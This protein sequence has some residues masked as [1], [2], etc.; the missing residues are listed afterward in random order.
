MWTIIKYDKKKLSFLKNDF[1]SKLGKDFIFYNPRLKI[2]KYNKNKLKKIEINLLGDYIFCFHPKFQKLDKVKDNLKYCRGLK[3]FL[4]GNHESQSEIKN[5][6]HKC[7]SLEDNDGFV[8]KTFFELSKG[9]EYKFS[10]GPFTSQIFKIINFQKN[11]IDILL[12]HLKTTVNRKDFL[13]S[14][15]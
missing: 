10:N 14:P 13:F 5:F 12:G 15:V 11:K 7:K 1:S 9:L 6:I 3:Y 8:S 2:E 4:G